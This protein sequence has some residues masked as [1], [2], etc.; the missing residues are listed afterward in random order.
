MVNQE[1]EDLIDNIL[2]EN[3]NTNDETNYHHHHHYHRTTHAMLPTPPSITP[4]SS[5]SNMNKAF[6]ELF[7]AAEFGDSSISAMIEAKM[8]AQAVDAQVSMNEPETAAASN[9]DADDD[10]QQQQQSTFLMRKRNSIARSR[11]GSFRNDAFLRQSTGSVKGANDNGTTAAAASTADYNNSSNNTLT[12]K[13]FKSSLKTD[14]YLGI[15]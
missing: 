8:A 2:N 4:P 5:S 6:D 1:S 12:K 7:A 13:A 15:F 3:S 11:N 10:D 9:I 14:D